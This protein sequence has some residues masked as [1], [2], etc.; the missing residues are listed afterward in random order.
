MKY[1][2]FVKSKLI[3]EKIVLNYIYNWKNLFVLINIYI[4]NL[5]LKDKCIVGIKNNYFKQD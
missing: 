1:V 3:Q 2:N 5:K 4:L